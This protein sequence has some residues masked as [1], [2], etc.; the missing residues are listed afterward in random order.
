MPTLRRLQTEAASPTPPPQVV[1]GLNWAIPKSDRLEATTGS[2]VTRYI[3]QDSIRQ[4]RGAREY[5]R[6]KPYARVVA[7][8]AAVRSDRVGTIPPFN[9]IRLYGSTAT[10][11]GTDGRPHGESER[12][13]GTGLVA[14]RVVELLGSILPSEDGQEL[15][16]REVGELVNRARQSQ[17]DQAI[18]PGFAP[19]GAARSGPDGA[20]GTTGTEIEEPLPA[21]TTVLA[22]S[23]SETEDDEAEVEGAQ[24]RMIRVQRGETLQKLLER[25]GTDAYLARSMVEAAASVLGERALP[26]GHV[27]ELSLEPSLDNQDQLE[28]VGFTVRD[29]KGE[30][31]VSI[32]RNAA[33][34][35]TARQPSDRAARR[36]AGPREGAQPAP[37]SLYASVYLSALSQGLPVETVMQILR[38]HVYE[39]DF[40]RRAR[41]TDE[42]ELLFDVREEGRGSDIAMGEMLFTAITAGGQTN[43]YYRYRASDGTIDYYDERGNNSRKFLIRKPVRS[44]EARLTSGFGFRYHPLLNTRKMHSGVDWSVP[45]GTPIVAS[46]NGVIEEAGPKGQYGNYIRIRHANGYHTTYAHL[47]RIANGIAEGVRVR[48][49]QLIALSGN[50]GFSTGPHVHYE[51][52]VNSRFVDPMTIQVPRERRLYGRDL[53][54]FRKERERIDGLLRRQPVRVEQTASF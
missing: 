4:R 23:I 16:A 7:R 42:L 13:A 54:D 27:V 36:E 21:S 38:L 46:G 49:N 33:G 8:L 26:L 52:L 39:T 3:V 50:T 47:S 10:T 40:R 51:V 35:F 37:A 32:A 20:P 25:D 41:A 34:E 53:A 2:M 28:A 31:V 44:E 17:S 15:D 11:G 22:K 30:H 18:R 12:D 5:I 24:T 43:R 9:P 48:Q 45:V 14:M 19:E 6:N 29:G 1:T